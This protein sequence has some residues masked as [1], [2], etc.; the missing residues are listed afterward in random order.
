MYFHVSLPAIA[1]CHRHNCCCAGSLQPASLI[2]FILPRSKEL[3]F[4]WASADE[5]SNACYAWSFY[6]CRWEDWRFAP[7]LA[8]LC[9]VDKPSSVQLGFSKNMGHGTSSQLSFWITTWMQ[10]CMSCWS[11]QQ[12]SAAQFPQK[13]RRRFP[14]AKT[15]H[16]VWKCPTGSV[17]QTKS[18]LTSPVG[19]Q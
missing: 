2:Q 9:M 10:T 7:W 12:A 14:R 15:S 16:L 5:A 13:S 1:P 6:N 17:P 19:L 4:H 3:F 18:G 8:A 11:Q